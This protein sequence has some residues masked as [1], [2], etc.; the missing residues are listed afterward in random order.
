MHFNLSFYSLFLPLPPPYPNHKQ[1]NKASNS[2]TFCKRHMQ[3]NKKQSKIIAYEKSQKSFS[4]KERNN[5]IY[6]DSAKRR[7]LQSCVFFKTPPCVSKK[8]E[9]NLVI[10]RKW[11]LAFKLTECLLFYS[12]ISCR[13]KNDRS[14][15]EL[16]Y[17]TWGFAQPLISYPT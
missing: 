8:V 14:L 13:C 17:F 12:F 4:K 9:K 2:M 10:Y 15:L 16:F 6:K 7:F 3:K 1:T 5:M 11:I